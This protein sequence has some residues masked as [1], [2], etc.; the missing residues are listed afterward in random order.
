MLA[1][2]IK[3]FSLADF[4]KGI[5]EKPEDFLYSRYSLREFKDEIVQD[6]VL[7]KA[8]KLAAKSPSVCNRQAWKVYRTSNQD[9]KNS[10]L[11][12]QN[13]NK[14]FGANIPNLFVVCSDLRA[15]FSGSEH[16]QYWIDG[17]M[18][19]MSLIYAFHSLGVATCP[20]N[21]SQAPDNDKLVRRYFNIRPYHTIIMALAVGYPSEGSPE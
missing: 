1:Q 7:E 15:F 11:R 16:Y 10:F 4:S 12:Y 8:V 2:G 9:V 21:W 5:L 19:A 14:P 20:L 17:G 13:G 6:H 18:F 3:T